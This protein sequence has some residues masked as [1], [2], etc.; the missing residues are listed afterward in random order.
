MVAGKQRDQA[1]R[2]IA[3]H[4]L[5]P[6]LEADGV[7]M[8]ESPAILEWIAA[9]WPQPALLPA[10]PEAAAIVRGMAA[11]IARHDG[12]FAYGDAPTLADCYLLPQVYNAE[13]FDVPLSHYRS[14][15]GKGPFVACRARGSSSAAA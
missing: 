6:A 4:G 14:G 10:T 1:C 12:S 9:R 13:R 7:L 3:P 11:L 8:I 15:C 5:V 2:A